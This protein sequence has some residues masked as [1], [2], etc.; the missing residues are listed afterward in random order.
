MK[1]ELISFKLCPYVQ[2]SIITLLEKA[3]PF[4]IN[5]IDL[6]NPPPWFLEI[7]PMG[8]VPVLRVSDSV[9]FESA[10]INEYLDE[11]HPPSLLPNDPLKKA[12]NRAWIEFASH[13]LSVIYK[14]VFTKEKQAFNQGI[15]SLKNEMQPLEKMMGDGPYFNGDAFSLVDTAFAPAFKHLSILDAIEPLNLYAALP[16][17]DHWK[18]NLLQ[19]KSVQASVVDEFE[20]LYHDYLKA[21]GVYLGKQL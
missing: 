2:R 9:L 13:L 11:I 14:A 21:N 8:K 20:P 3:V 1:F 6:S 4:D 12:H 7:S 5:Y 19:R 15:E 17:I 10:V 18:S 16:N